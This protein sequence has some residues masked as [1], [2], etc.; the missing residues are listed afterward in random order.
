MVIRLDCKK[1][2]VNFL[3][4][5]KNYTNVTSCIYFRLSLWTTL[6]AIKTVVSSSITAFCFMHK[7]TILLPSLSFVLAK[8][9]CPT[10]LIL[11]CLMWISL[12]R[13]M[14]TRHQRHDFPCRAWEKLGIELINTSLATLYFCVEVLSWDSKCK[15]LMVSINFNIFYSVYLMTELC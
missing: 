15:G 9:L 3:N 7:R 14:P 13:P 10:L 6:P 4:Y 2:K 1:R 8:T 5:F 12:D 11:F